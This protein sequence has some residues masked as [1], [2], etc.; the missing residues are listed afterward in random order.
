MIVGLAVM[1]V[2]VFVTVFLAVAVST[3]L[4]GGDW[5]PSSNFPS[6]AFDPFNLAASVLLPHGTA[7]FVAEW[8]RARRIRQGRWFMGS[9]AGRRSVSANYVRLALG[10][11]LAGYLSLYLW[12]L[13][14]GPPTWAFAISI[15]AYSLLPAATGW[16]YA[17]HLDNAELEKRPSRVSEISSQALVTAFCWL[18]ASHAWL[19]IG[20]RS[21]LQGLDFLLLSALLGALVGGSLAWYIPE[22][23]ANDRADPLTDARTSRIEALRRAAAERLGDGVGAGWLQDAHPALDYKSPIEAAANVDGYEKAL[24]LLQK[25]QPVAA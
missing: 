23:A 11:A 10:C 12:G 13:F 25:P 15:A 7:I 4:G 20:G 18:V 24:C 17:Y 19:A 1:A 9:G 5:K 6:T 3:M 21:P 2:C 16:F 8:I 14:F 22:A